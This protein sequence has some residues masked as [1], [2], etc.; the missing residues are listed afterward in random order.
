MAFQA[1]DHTSAVANSIVS[2]VSVLSVLSFGEVISQYFNMISPVKSDQAAGRIMYALVLTVLSIWFQQSP[3]LA[4]TFP[5]IGA[6]VSGA[7]VLLSAISWRDVADVYLQQYLPI[8]N[9]LMYAIALAVLAV[10]LQGWL[11]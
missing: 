6:Y 9:K 3:P 10:V 8:E 1:Q 5:A 2:G 11:M 7:I 4:G